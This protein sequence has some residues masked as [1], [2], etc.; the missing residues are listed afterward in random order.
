[1]KLNPTH[2]PIVTKGT[3]E[4]IQGHEHRPIYLPHGIG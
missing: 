1:M 4:Y 3:K 2:L